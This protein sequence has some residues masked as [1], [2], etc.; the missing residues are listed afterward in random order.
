MC[1]FTISRQII[2]YDDKV[3]IDALNGV[4]RSTNYRGNINISFKVEDRATTIMSDHPLNHYRTNKV[5]WW[6]CIFLQL[7][8]ITW[9]VLWLMTR[10][11]E[12]LYVDWPCRIYRRSDGSWPNMDEENPAR[13]H[14]GVQSEA[15]DAHATNNVRLAVMSEQEWVEGWRGAIVRAAEDR[16]QGRLYESDRRAATAVERRNAERRF[17]SGQRAKDAR[18]RGFVGATL[19]LISGAADTFRDFRMARGWGNND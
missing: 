19:G 10:R 9:P 5:I 7:W 6:T 1:R 11:W 17:E 4:L 2:N 12:M 18:R 14:E 16:K 15:A 3:L 8:I 13:I